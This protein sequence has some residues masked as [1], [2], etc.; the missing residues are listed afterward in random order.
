MKNKVL[1]I[2][3]MLSIGLN[4]Q[5]APYASNR[6]IAGLKNDLNESITDLRQV[7]ELDFLFTEYSINTIKPLDISPSKSLNG[8][9]LVL[10]FNDAITID[11]LIQKL[12]KSNL[13]DYVEPD[14]I[15]KGSGEKVEENIKVFKQ[16]IKINTE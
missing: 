13:F 11:L 15:L 7:K 9:P 3:F 5:N 8:R 2:L 16:Y 4:A 10:I 1:F 12:Q 14:Y 6:I